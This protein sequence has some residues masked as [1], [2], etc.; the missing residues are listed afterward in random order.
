MSFFDAMRY[1][2]R[3]AFRRAGLDR[4][5]EEELRHYG[6]L[7]HAQRMRDAM[8]R[9]SRDRAP[10]RAVS[11]TSL[12]DELRGMS[13]LGSALDQAA[14]DAR[15]AVRTLRTTPVFAVVAILTLALG[16]GANA[17]IFGIVDAVALKPLPFPQPEQLVRIFSTRNGLVVGSP[18]PWDVE[19][20]AHAARSFQHLV[21]YDEWR[22]TVRLGD[23]PA[24][25]EEMLVG[26]VSTDYFR[27][28]GISPIAGRLFTSDE[29]HR[30]RNF[31][32]VISAG[33]WRQ[34][35]G[36]RPDVLGRTIRI[37]DE[38]YAIV[39]VV[40]DLDLAWVNARRLTARVWTPWGLTPSQPVD[41]SR[42]ATGEDAIAR[43]RPGVSL[44]QARADV[45]QLATRLGET[46]PSDRPYGLTV[47]PLV[48]SR[49]GTLAPLLGILGGAVA[50]V[51]LIAC[52]NLASLLHARNAARQR[53]MLVRTALGASR[54]RVARQLLVETMVLAGF[55]GAAG[56]LLAA[57]GCAAVSRWHPS[58]F[59]QLSGLRVNG[60]VLA[61]ALGISLATSIVFGAWP[62]LSTSRVDLAERLRA[63]GRTGTASR[64]QRRVRSA[65]VIVQIALALVLAASTAILTQSVVRLTHQRL[66]FVP[67]HLFKAHVYISP[68]RYPTSAA[69]ARFADALGNEI[70]GM[71]GVGAATVTMGY[72]PAAARWLQPVAIEGHA[73]ERLA[74]R[75]TVFFSVADE[76]YLRTYHTRLIRGRDFR[77]TD[78]AGGTA[79][80]IVSESFVRRY[81]ADRDPIGARMTLGNPIVPVA[82]PTPITIVGV[83][84]DVKND[85]LYKPAYP[86][87][88]GLYRQLPEF[89]S[90]FKD[91]VAR[92]T[93]DPAALGGSVQRML[94]A[95][96]PNL[97]LGEVA[98]MSDVVASAAGG[99]TYAALLIGAFAVLGMVLAAIGTYGVVSYM[100]AQRSGEIGIRTALGARPS[101]IVRMV[102]G[103]G[104]A[105]G[106]SGAMLGLLG[107]VAAARVLA[108]QVF[109]VSAADP[110]TLLASAS[111]LVLVTAIASAIPAWRALHIDPAAALHTD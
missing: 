70:R 34:R 20:V 75:P 91:I 83:F 81:L 98:T 26:L 49:V 45:A 21:P 14:Q 2:W 19:D 47:A 36:A 67:D 15:Y 27:T 18:S 95:M 38:P 24:A 78:V 55:G 44:Q 104:C 12:R 30:G 22:K 84:E 31:V 50:L 87:A 13:R 85:G 97:A 61:F 74:D 16:V 51:L 48:E 10:R 46:Y 39:G 65:L 88:V 57:A 77:S 25:P 33:L 35:Y 105:L 68:A 29:E 58:Q 101:S 62:A 6:E 9:P 66:G 37:N 40:P 54:S 86:Q 100:V 103:S 43:L 82:A 99:T 59:P 42:G 106:A 60:A 32:A 5:L 4:D 41:A 23:G 56:F 71:S 72:P 93:G 80:A 108:G 17:T 69:V 79:V 96:D 63:G 52:T 8:A 107:S 109:G 64:K 28:L 92:T 111:G 53:E 94:R 102:V 110:T 76:W 90:E 73:L 7:D 89:S 3:A 11:V 1:R